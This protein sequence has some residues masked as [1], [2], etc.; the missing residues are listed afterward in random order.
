MNEYDFDSEEAIDLSPEEQVAATALGL[1]ST[2]RL[3]K[4]AYAE[5]K[6]KAEDI[7]AQSSVPSK[8]AREAAK[9]IVKGGG[10]KS[11]EVSARAFEK[12]L[13]KGPI[14]VPSG[15][16]IS[17]LPQVSGKMGEAI[18]KAKR[19][20]AGVPW[21][22]AEGV[23][24]LPAPKSPSFLE[25]ISSL[26][27]K[28][29]P[30]ALEKIGLSK[31]AIASLFEKAA[32]VAKMGTK[33]T[34]P[35]GLALDAATASPVGEE[36]DIPKNPFTGETR[37]LSRAEMVSL[38]PG[39]PVDYY[40]PAGRSEMNPPMASSKYDSLENIIADTTRPPEE[41]D[42]RA[43]AAETQ[44]EEANQ[45]LSP[46]ARMIS[47]GEP[48]AAQVAKQ[49][50]EAA[51]GKILG[52]KSEYEDLLARYKDAEERQRLAQLGVSLGQAG[53]RIGSALAM[54]KPGDQ[55]FYEQQ[56][57]LAGEITDEFKEEEAV[58]REGEK[59]DPKSETSVSM[60]NLLKEQGITVPENISAAFIEKQYPQ[61]A[62]IINRREAAQARKEEMKL[63]FADIATRRDETK[64]EKKDKF[65][66]ALRK[67]TTT[68]AL[69]KMF[70][71]YN[72]AKRMGTAL[73]E[74]AKNPTAYS[75]Y[76]TLMG[77]LKAL[78]GDESVVREA[79]V[80]LGMSATSLANKVKNWT[81]RLVTGK[82]LQPSQRDEMVKA[83]K[84][85]SETARK[86]YSDSISPIM[87]QAESVG[88]D[89]KMLVGEGF[90]DEPASALKPQDKIV[91]EKDGKQFRL[92]KAQL[93]RAISQGYKE[94]K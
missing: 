62:N 36:S 65:I 48:T 57:K 87:K 37:Q 75:D 29:G 31:N 35:L 44:A 22:P 23:I 52:Q 77:G 43:L 26:A 82:S 20:A 10:Q 11:A 93:Q 8:T 61:F 18:E 85:L 84:V 72:T 64:E 74:F 49:T 50:E 32:P 13:E 7:V 60:R 1:G 46:K 89:K 4:K 73:E 14:K 25:K 16:V 80:R 33:L 58:R 17:D 5:F 45:V 9:G 2:K 68:G 91:V 88:I 27:K 71:N 79:E 70:S 69:G 90:L 67:E 51:L 59:N 83:V 15:S 3:S 24:N 94:V 40:P 34:G 21:Q 63:R 76:A 66:Q 30:D 54:V 41:S 42:V 6:K 28:A 53:E 86:Q 78:Q 81:D 92:P 47:A 12:A 56:M 39:T 19:A 55:S 38:S